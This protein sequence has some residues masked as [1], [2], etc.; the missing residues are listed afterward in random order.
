MD[1]NDTEI[2]FQAILSLKT[3]SCGFQLYHCARVQIMYC[4]FVILILRKII[5]Q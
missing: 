1:K 4:N 3:E 5:L 2:T